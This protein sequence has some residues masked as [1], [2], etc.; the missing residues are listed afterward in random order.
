MH[1]SLFVLPAE[2]TVCLWLQFVTK[3]DTVLLKAHTV[4]QSLRQFLILYL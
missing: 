4:L 2:A 1:V 3:L